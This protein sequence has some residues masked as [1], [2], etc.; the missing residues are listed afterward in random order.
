MSGWYCKLSGDV[1]GPFSIDEIRYLKFRGEL[2][3]DDEVRQG[4]AGN[5]VTVKS[6]KMLSGDRAASVRSHSRPAIKPV[7]PRSAS[8]SSPASSSSR[9]ES[10]KPLEGLDDT[11]PTEQLSP[12][13]PSL[14]PALPE[15]P[16]QI[17]RREQVMIG[18]CIGAGTALLILLIVLL[19]LWPAGVG[20]SRGS[21]AGRGVG[22]EQGD[23][24]GEGAGDGDGKNDGDSSSNAVTEESS[25]VEA[26]PETETG[27][28]ESAEESEPT[29]P[30]EATEEP[31][32]TEATDTPAT[33]D[34]P[35]NAPLPEEDMSGAAT[36]TVTELSNAEGGGGAGL[37]EFDRRLDREGAKSGD[38]QISLLWNNFNDL[39]L[40]I[41][42]PSGE[43]ISYQRSHSRCGGELDVDM[44]AG[45]RKSAEPVENVYWPED[46]APKGKFVVMVNHYARHGG[47]DPTKFTVA[48][49]VDGKTKRFTGAV[50]SGQP[51][52]TVHSF[53]RR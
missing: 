16:Q 53:T 1:V 28:D 11:A 29:E 9:K 14:P 24:L 25:P 5:W 50:S 22:H 13:I 31:E 49:T 46:G 6:V 19:L 27:D 36:F 41:R 21:V 34:P 45:G 52:Q 18:A 47:R 7:A 37:G 10:P 44:N 51:M 17:G 12:M 48:V 32:P 43:I 4:E 39:D 3:P 2:A 26:S 8:V 33:T 35:E 20:G 30:T 42:C 23:G 38:V 40:H 15:R